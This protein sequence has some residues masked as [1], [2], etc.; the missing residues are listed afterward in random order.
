MLSSE[1]SN[2]PNKPS[3]Y[4][5]GV[6]HSAEVRP[7]V[8]LRHIERVG[9]IQS[10]CHVSGVDSL[11]IHSFI[12]QKTQLNQHMIQVWSKEKRGKTESV[13]IKKLIK[14]LPA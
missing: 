2:Q 10:H 7:Q 8:I 9:E 13:S 6:Q 11:L 1:L 3:V 14:L 12:L 4:L 5:H